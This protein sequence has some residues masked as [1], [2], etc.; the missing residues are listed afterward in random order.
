VNTLLGN[1]SEA[2]QYFDHASQLDPHIHIEVARAT[3]LKY[4]EIF[5]CTKM[6]FRGLGKLDEALDI[7]RVYTVQNH[8]DDEALTVLGM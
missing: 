4:T 6:L 1:F 3:A 2:T 5:F 7:I 8:K